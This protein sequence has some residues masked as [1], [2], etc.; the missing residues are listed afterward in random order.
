MGWIAIN[1]FTEKNE[2][3]WEDIF[4]V[5]KEFLL[6]SH[7]LRLSKLAVL[8]T[9]YDRGSIDT[10]KT[11][12]VSTWKK[13]LLRVENIRSLQYVEFKNQSECGKNKLSL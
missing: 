10:W 9:M 3:R 8:Y 12:L 11:D 2:I 4:F 7:L 13:N 6:S 5:L 1:S